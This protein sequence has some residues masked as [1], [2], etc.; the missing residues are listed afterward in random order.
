M[1]ALGC[2]GLPLLP[3]RLVG[4]GLVALSGGGPKQI[5]AATALPVVA[6][7]R[8]DAEDQ[9]AIRRA[10]ASAE[11]CLGSLRAGQRELGAAAVDV[12]AQVRALFVKVCA[13]AEELGRARRFL[14][15][16]DPEVIA[17]HRAEAEVSSVGAS[18]AERT[19]HQATLGA[20]EDRA[21]H[22]GTVAGEVG[23]LNAR[24]LSAV[25]SLETLNTRLARAALSSEERS[26]R[27]EGVLESLRA[28]EVEAERALQAYA[29]TAREISRLGG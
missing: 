11:G 6:W 4:R 23:V 5:T 3:F 13:V 26:A 25:A 10:R 27:V 19:A 17:R 20:M 21:R 12:A 28:Q 16:N 1:A 15:E 24:L 29:A 2:L 9:P 14:R 18:L 7:Q 22:A 8:I